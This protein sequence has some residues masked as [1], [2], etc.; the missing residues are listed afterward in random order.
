M[1]DLPA[2]TPTTHA[3]LP[4][5][6]ARTSLLPPAPGRH[7]WC[8]IVPPSSLAQFDRPGLEA[9][10]NARLVERLWERGVGC[11]RFDLVPPAQRVTPSHPSAFGRQLRRAADVLERLHRI[12][13]HA[14]ATILA[15]GDGVDVAIALS[16]VADGM[17]WPALRG[18]LLTPSA[19]ALL[20]RS[21][22]DQAR[23]LARTVAADERLIEDPARPGVTR[24][25]LRRLGR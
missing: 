8:V 10:L 17:P 23:D 9:T 16:K 22:T 11:A 6:H 20:P 4:I 12:D 25:L 2:M 13:N 24:S 1:T 7:H 15:S 14:E 19:E 18:L 3:E 5:E 21:L